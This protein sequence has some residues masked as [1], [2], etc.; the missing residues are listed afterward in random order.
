MKSVLILQGPNLNM[1]GIR[2]KGIYGDETAEN[3]NNQLSE[4][5]KKLDLQCEIF[6]SNW[7]GALIDKIHEAKDKHDGVIINPGAFT[8]YSYAMRDAIASVQIP[9]IEVH[10]SN[11][12]QRED[13]RH[14]SVLAPV[15]V[16]QISGFGKQSYLLGLYA[17]KDLIK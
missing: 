9:F 1:L 17:L 5:C 11:I 4:H 2:E 15:C 16:G 6:Q 12:Y 3:I 10:M 13:F 14:I 7:E 8:H